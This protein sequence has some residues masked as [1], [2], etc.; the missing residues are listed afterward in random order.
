MSLCR[1]R[2][3]LIRVVLAHAV[4]SRLRLWLG[5]SLAVGGGRWAVLSGVTG[6]WQRETGMAEDG[7]AGIDRVTRRGAGLVAAIGLIGCLVGC[8]GASSTTQASASSAVSSEQPSATATE[9]GSPTSSASPTASP[10][11]TASR[12]GGVSWKHLGSMRFSGIIAVPQG[13]LASCNTAESEGDFVLCSSR[14]LV[15]W[16]SPPEPSLYVNAGGRQ[17]FPGEAV[18]VKSGYSTR[19]R[20][21]GPD[22]TEWYS[23]DGVHWQEGIPASE[24]VA[25]SVGPCLPD[26]YWS[27]A[28]LPF[29]VSDSR[30]RVALAGVDRYV[31]KSSGNYIFTHVLVSSDGW[32][33]WQEVTL[34]DPLWQIYSEPQILPDGT[35]IAICTVMPGPL[36]SGVVVGGNPDTVFIISKDGVHWQTLPDVQGAAYMAVIGTKIFASFGEWGGPVSGSQDRGATWLPMTDTAG[37]SVAGYYVEAVNGRVLVFDGDCVGPGVL[38]WVS[39]PVAA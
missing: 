20:G 8:G 31:S 25:G 7:L 23:P 10:T 37:S 33:T 14:D 11:P 30:S 24:V 15:T 39:T 17:L 26:P 19:E 18:P 2:R 9:A 28:I 21:T 4:S 32:S 35:W 6:M 12:V 5:Y 38:L 1:R 29:V 34:P 27:C 3:G 16:K 22:R 13:Y 36:P